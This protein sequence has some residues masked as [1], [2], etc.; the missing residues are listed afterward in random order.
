MN[1][2]IDTNIFIYRED[3]QVVPSSLS[4]LLRLFEENSVIILVHPMSKEDVR[5]DSDAAR[6]EISSSK[7][8][9]YPELAAPPVS[10]GD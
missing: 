1:V 5:R 4:S 6:K 8:S 9:V 2:L 7:L 3:H 10:Q